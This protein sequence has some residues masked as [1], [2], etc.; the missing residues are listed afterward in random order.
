MAGR[1]PR[2]PQ[3]NPRPVHVRF[4]VDEVIL[5]QVLLSVFLILTLYI[6]HTTIFL[7]VFGA[8]APGG[9][10]PPHSRA[11]HFTHGTS[12]SVRLLRT[13]DRP[14]VETSVWQHT[15]LNRQTSMHL[16]G[17]EPTVSTS[18]RL[19]TYALHRMATGTGVQLYYIHQIQ[20]QV[21]L[22][23]LLLVSSPK[24]FGLTSLAILRESS[25]TCIV[26][27]NLSVT[28]SHI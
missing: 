27:F 25:V 7:F 3:F 19:Q 16:V 24:C 28:S 12:Q 18:E 9:S 4:L 15:T 6:F 23:Y 20:Y 5:C 26:R 10:G 17:F 21:V 2:R 11:F 13:I 14:V 22:F 8:T 1:W